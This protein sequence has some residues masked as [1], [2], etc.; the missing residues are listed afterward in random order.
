MIAKRDEQDTD[1]VLVISR[2]VEWSIREEL[3]EMHCRVGPTQVI[4]VLQQRQHDVHHDI[5]SIVFI[6][7][8]QDGVEGIGQLGT[9]LIILG[10]DHV[11]HQSIQDRWQSASHR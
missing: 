11:V 2:V 4:V 10:R 5:E 1:Q 3:V 9:V 7:G 8:N 6:N